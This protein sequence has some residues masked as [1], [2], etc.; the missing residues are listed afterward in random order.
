MGLV[1]L[2]AISLATYCVINLATRAFRH[3]AARCGVQGADRQTEER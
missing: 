1:P 2:K 3:N